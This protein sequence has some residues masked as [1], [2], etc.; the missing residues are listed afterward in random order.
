M[1]DCNHDNFITPRQPVFS[2]TKSATN[3][4]GLMACT[5]HVLSCI[6]PFCVL[7]SICGIVSI[8]YHPSHV[9]TSTLEVAEPRNVCVPT[10]GR[11]EV[12]RALKIDY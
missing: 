11:L 8:Y 10:V 4:C 7:E 12:D 2:C 1:P 5:C 3:F 6:Q 9:N